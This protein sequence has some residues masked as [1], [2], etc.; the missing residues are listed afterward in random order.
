MHVRL[1]RFRL[2]RGALQS[3]VGL[4]EAR[5]LAAFSIGAG[6]GDATSGFAVDGWLV[7]LSRVFRS[8]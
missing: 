2:R 1:V 5:I 6:G 3:F 8:A 4:Y 7:R